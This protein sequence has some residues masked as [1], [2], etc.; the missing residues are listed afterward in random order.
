VGSIFN[1]NPSRPVH[2][3][4]TAWVKNGSKTGYVAA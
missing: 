4:L 2:L 3:R 1:T